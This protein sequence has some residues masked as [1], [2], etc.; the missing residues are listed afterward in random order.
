[1]GNS[2]T[3]SDSLLHGD[4]R[5]DKSTLLQADEAAPEIKVNSRMDTGGFISLIGRFSAYKAA[6]LLSILFSSLLM[7]G[8]LSNP[9]ELTGITAHL[10]VVKF[11]IGLCFFLGGIALLFTTRKSHGIA[12]KI[13]KFLATFLLLVIV[14]LTLAEYLFGVNLPIDQL[15]VRDTSLP[16]EG[17]AP[18]RMSLSTATL[19][20]LLSISLVLQCFGSVKLISLSQI[21]SVLVGLGGLIGVKSYL[22]GGDSFSSYFAFS[23]M[24]IHTSI[25]F[26]VMGV[27]MFLVKPD[28]GLTIVVG[29]K[30]V[31]GMLIR[32]FTLPLVVSLVGINLLIHQGNVAGLYDSALA[33]SLSSVTSSVLVIYLAMLLARNINQ[34]Q[35]QVEQQNT[36]LYNRSA[37]LG[38][39]RTAMDQH[40]IVAITDSRGRITYVND[41]FCAISKYARE[42]LL[43]RDHRIINSGF[44]PKAFIR[45]LW[46]T[47]STGRVWKGE[48]KNRAKDGTH[49]WVDTTIVPF[50][51]TAGTLTQYVAI[52][53][54]I[55]ERKS[56][57]ER[58]QISRDQLEQAM[59]SAD[60]ASWIFDVDSQIFT[61]NDRFYRIFG[62]TAEKEGGYQMAARR[63]LQKLCHPEDADGIRQEIVKAINSPEIDQVFTIEYRIR[64]QDNDQVRDVVVNYQRNFDTQGRAVRVWGAIQDI[65]D[66]KQAE[67]EL[68]AAR[69]AADSANRAKSAFLANMSHEI[70]TPLNAIAGMVELIE[71]TKD[72]DEQSKMLRITRQS[73]EALTGIINDVLDLSKIEAGMLDINPEP[74]SVRDI[75]T[76]AVEVFSSSASANSL[77]LRQVCDEQV[78]EAV[79]CDPLR[80]RQILF[81]LLGNAIKFTRIGGVEVRAILQSQTDQ[82]VEIRLE[83][84]DTG[85]GISAES[86]AK[87]FQPFV[88]AEA[89]TTREFG[90]TGLGLAISRRLADLLGGNLTLQSELGEGTVMVLTLTLPLADPNSLPVTA[91]ESVK[92][93]LPELR[94]QLSMRRDQRKLL[95][96]DDNAINRKVLQR[97]LTVLGYTADEAENGKV[98]LEKWRVGDHAL[99]IT[100]CHMPEMDGYELAKSIRHVEW[101]EPQRAPI[102][103]VGY[104][105]DAGKDSRELCAAAGMDDVLIKPVALEAVGVMLDLWLTSMDNRKAGVKAEPKIVGNGDVTSPIDEQGLNAI[106]GGD[107]AF[108]KDI[109]RSFLAE[110]DDEADYFVSLLEDGDLQEIVHIAHRLKGAARTIAAMR[111]AEICGQIESAASK[112]DKKGVATMKNGLVQEFDKVRRHILSIGSLTA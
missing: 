57:E 50:L 75:V 95:I 110:K 89:D 43:G 13:V 77:Y 103:I 5:P 30:H 40:S 8:W 100:D 60:M 38:D 93:R 6:G 23:T 47:I 36:L 1:M 107:V 20:L 9:L 59:E 86:Q 46:D 78:P 90:G 21:L 29:N 104:T 16:Q 82:Q 81:N 44:H 41:K 56:I 17:T 25:L 22:F 84:A 106:T 64:R 73:T 54:D 96:V 55:S 19:F 14:S 101:S 37:E 70:R 83:V 18:G 66:R 61:W 108:G 71:H 2:K 105:A 111:L 58:L 74:V 49:Y 34:M 3:A 33:M 72:M 92:A 97:Q 12:D 11:N 27:G 10:P 24:A 85:I 91:G 51:D 87:L 4:A 28:N 7:Y 63:Y 67:R 62:T 15:F 69:K 52:R 53:T 42:E 31:G 35:T 45:E 48:I 65:T 109:L 98:A 68:E 102:V 99:L 39:L 80:L 94:A 76:S 88:Q 112:S 79:L 26:I 32:R